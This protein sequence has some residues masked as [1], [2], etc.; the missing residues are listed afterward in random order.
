MA[1]AGNHAYQSYIGSEELRGAISNWYHRFFNVELDINDHKKFLLLIKN[2]KK[3]NKKNDNTNGLA[4]YSITT[5]NYC[6]DPKGS[7]TAHFNSKDYNS[8][9][10]LDTSN[11]LVYF[12]K[13]TFYSV[14][15]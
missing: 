2:N 5:R 3:N 4:A 14:S 9:M 1:T 13:F 15:I 7:L 10:K 11:Y 6:E 12:S 8:A